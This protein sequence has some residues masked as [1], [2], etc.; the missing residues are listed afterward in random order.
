MAMAMLQPVVGKPAPDFSLV[1]TS[2]DTVTLRQFKR[3][4]TPVI[5]V[6]GFDHH[7]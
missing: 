1:S 6:I 5:A 2:G 7:W 3:D 4:A